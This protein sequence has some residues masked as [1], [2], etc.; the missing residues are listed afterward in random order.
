[1]SHALDLMLKHSMI[2]YLSDVISERYY[3]KHLTNEL[4]FKTKEY[5]FFMSHLYVY[6]LQV[7]LTYILW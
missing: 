5:E 1:M 6:K 2:V 7:T 4:V 3:L